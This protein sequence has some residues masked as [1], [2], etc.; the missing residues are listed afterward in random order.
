[1]GGDGL[2][3]L[4]GGRGRDGDGEGGGAARVCGCMGRGW[5][6]KVECLCCA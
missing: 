4:G 5:H 1:M 2:A 6:G 3:A